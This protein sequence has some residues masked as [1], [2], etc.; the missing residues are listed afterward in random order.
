[1]PA[2]WPAWP[3]WRPCS[4]TPATSFRN[5]WPKTDANAFLEAELGG[6]GG[7]GGL[8]GDAQVDGGDGPLRVLQAVAG[9]RADH[10]LARPHEPGVDGPQQAGHRCR[11]GRLAE[12]TLPLGQDPV[13]VEDLDVG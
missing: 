9:E 7:G 13:G 2:P 8:D 12:H 1:R 10:G 3:S 11:R 6:H 4:T 5:A